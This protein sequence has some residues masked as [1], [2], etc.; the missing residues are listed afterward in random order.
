M[1]VKSH[2]ISLAFLG[3]LLAASFSRNPQALPVSE[4]IIERD[5]YVLSYDG[6]HRQARWVYEFLTEERL[7]GKA[8]RSGNSFQEDPLIPAPLRSTAKD[9]RGSG[10]DRG[11]LC[12]AADAHASREKIKETFYFSNISPQLPQF[13]QGYWAM[14]E[15]HVRLLTKD[16]KALHVYTGPLYMPAEEDDGNRYVKYRVIGENDVAVPTH[17]FKVIFAEKQEGNEDRIAY[18]LPNMPIDSDTAL[19][20]FQVALEQVEKAAGMIFSH[21]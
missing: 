21:L 1:K 11:H 17:F 5:A 9:Y 3:S 20:Q 14:L 2:L 15:G 12:P 7:K 10:L 6:Q 18:I 4:Y 13:N 19:E 16:Y 8:K